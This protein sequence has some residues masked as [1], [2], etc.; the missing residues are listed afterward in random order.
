MSQ[1]K[2]GVPILNQKVRKSVPKTDMKVMLKKPRALNNPADYYALIPT[3]IRSERTEKLMINQSIIGSARSPEKSVKSF[4]GLSGS[5]MNRLR[6]SPVKKKK[7][8]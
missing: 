6:S 5:Q 3:S 8:K 1:K 4:T 7:K 2:L